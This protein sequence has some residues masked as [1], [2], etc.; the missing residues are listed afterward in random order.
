MRDYCSAHLESSLPC[1][2][3]S[4]L[5]FLCPPSSSPHLVAAQV[6]V[7]CPHEMP[8]LPFAKVFWKL[9]FPE[10]QAILTSRAISSTCSKSPFLK[11]AGRQ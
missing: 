9:P 11:G 10:H 7:L 2:R 6:S 1:L 8:F 3:V 5:L 4:H